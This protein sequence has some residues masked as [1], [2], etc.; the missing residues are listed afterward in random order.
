MDTGILLIVAIIS[1]AIAFLWQFFYHIFPAYKSVRIEESLATLAKC[2]TQLDK[3]ALPN[4]KIF[5]G[6]YLHDKLYKM[7]F[8]VLTNKANLNFSMLRHIKYNKASEDEMRKFKTELDSL[9]ETTKEIV[10]NAIFAVAK[11]FMLHNPCVLILSFFIIQQK[12]R[13]YIKQLKQQPKQ[14]LRKKMILSTEYITVNARDEDCLF[15]PC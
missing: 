14:F 10:D 7:L 2:L 3:D 15:V 12:K 11:I 8:Y 5:N 13:D 6:H 4:A 9:D 1:S